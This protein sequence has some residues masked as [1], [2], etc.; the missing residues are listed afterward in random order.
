MAGR[1]LAVTGGHRF[2]GDAFAAMLDAVCSELGWTWE[3]EEQPVAQRWWSARHAGVWDA[4]LLH[5]IPGLTLARGVEPE[6]TSPS[7]EVRLGVLELL[8][9][10]Q[11]VVAT[12]HALA[13]WP[14]WDE[15]AT[16]LGGRFLYAPGLLRGSDVPAS[17]YRMATYRVDVVA[18]E[19]PVC[20]GVE[21]FEVAD[22]L[23]L[24]PVFADEVTPLLATTA[25]TS[26][27]AMIDTYREVRW[28]E[29]VPAA[30]QA[31][32][33]LVGWARQHGP[34][35]IVYVLPGHTASTMAHPGYRTIVRNACEWVAASSR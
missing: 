20:A 14:D 1:L 7:D 18:G 24:C 21:P 19:H 9:A 17:G 26:P 33:P 10:G 15:W 12:H 35:R 27:A 2:D 31:G 11:G 5:D 25:D 30:A 29:R 6:V 32:S 34:S 28:G 22:E 8:A 13:G 23:Y 4:I 16:V 3:H